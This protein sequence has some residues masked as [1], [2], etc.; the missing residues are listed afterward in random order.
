MAGKARSPFSQRE[1]HILQALYHLNEEQRKAILR[2]ADSKLVRRICECAL[3]IL[4]GNVP[5]G[6]NHK[7]RLRQHAPTLRVLAKPEVSL[8][9]KKK[10]IVQRGSGFLP[11]LLSL[12]HI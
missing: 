1:K 9:R 3:N 8:A 2:K 11:V 7:S 10:L 12:I 4:V 5:L 6:K